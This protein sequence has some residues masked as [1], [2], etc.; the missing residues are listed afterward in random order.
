MCPIEDSR[1]ITNP[2]WA[3]VLELVGIER[4]KPSK[5][6]KAVLKCVLRDETQLQNP[7]ATLVLTAAGLFG[8][9]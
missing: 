3:G 2:A 7:P 4:A 1:V 8:R 9:A 6:L 5:V